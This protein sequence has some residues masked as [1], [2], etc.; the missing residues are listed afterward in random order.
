M[1][2]APRIWI[3]GEELGSAAAAFETLTPDTFPSIIDSGLVNAPCKKS[4]LETAVTAEVNS[5]LST[6]P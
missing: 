4:L 2:E 1:E 6:E 5:F 3:L